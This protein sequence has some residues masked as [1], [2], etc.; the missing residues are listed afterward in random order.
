MCRPSRVFSAVA[1]SIGKFLPILFVGGAIFGLIAA[2]TGSID[3]FKPWLIAAY[4]VFIIAMLTGAL[5][6]DP[7]AQRVA[8]ASAASGDDSPSDEHVAAVHDQRA[9]IASAV[10]MSAIVVLNFVLVFKPGN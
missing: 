4:I 7:W 10:L 8:T 3:F 6:S 5:V 2:F 1:A 9:F